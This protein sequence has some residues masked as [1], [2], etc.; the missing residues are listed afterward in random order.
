[1]QLDSEGSVSYNIGRQWRTLD[2]TLELDSR[3]GSTG[4]V[5]EQFQVTADNRVLYTGNVRSGQSL[6]VRLTVAGVSQLD[7]SN[8]LV[9]GSANGVSP[10][11]D[12]AELLG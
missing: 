3:S 4:A 1:M 9:S 12:N 11:W 5:T 2:M 6:H 10:V 8:S 7:L